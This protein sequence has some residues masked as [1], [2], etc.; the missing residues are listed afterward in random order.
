MLY[1]L[2]EQSFAIERPRGRSYYW[3]RG[4]VNFVRVRSGLW[5]VSCCAAQRSLTISLDMYLAASF[6]YSNCSSVS[7]SCMLVFHKFRNHPTMFQIVSVARHPPA[8]LSH[9]AAVD[10]IHDHPCRPHTHAAKRQ[11]LGCLNGYR[12]PGERRKRCDVVAAWQS[13]VIGIIAQLAIHSEP[14]APE[15]IPQ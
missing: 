15:V 4:V 3:S 9:W 1:I 14:T 13:S 12:G 5:R 6:M 11:W 2:T 8:E 7:L 10:G